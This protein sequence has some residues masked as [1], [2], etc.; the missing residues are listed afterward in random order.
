MLSGHSPA[1]QPDIGDPTRPGLA[2][3][4]LVPIIVTG[5]SFY[6]RQLGPLTSWGHRNNKCEV[7]PKVYVPSSAQNL[8]VAF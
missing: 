6:P 8:L 7:S 4:S 3:R 2:T 1:P 5:L